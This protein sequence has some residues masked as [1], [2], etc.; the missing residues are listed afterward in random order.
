MPAEILPLDFI[1]ADPDVRDG[2]PLI[3]GTTVAVA[4]LVRDMHY[5]GLTLAELGEK[6]I[7]TLADVHAALAYYYTHQD[8]MDALVQAARD[9]AEVLRDLEA[10]RAWL[11]SL[12]P[13]I[14]AFCEQWQIT[15]FAV[16]GSV[17]RE[18]FR[19][20]SDVDVLVTFAP[21]ARISLLDFLPMEEELRAIFEREIDL[22]DRG[23]VEQS[24]NPY[25]RRSILASAEVLHVAA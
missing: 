23:G 6:Y 17:L 19:V 7:L 10:R 8:E 4:D 15:E 21:E 11:A 16:F 24:T 20:D 3:A 25:R 13:Q 12:K 18:D 14:A 1:V 22:A 2:Q 5:A 9:R